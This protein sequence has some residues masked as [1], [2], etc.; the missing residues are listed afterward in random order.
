MSTGSSGFFQSFFNTPHKKKFSKNK[1]KIYENENFHENEKNYDQKNYE[2][3]IEKNNLKKNEKIETVKSDD[4]SG[5]SRPVSF[6]SRN[7]SKNHHIEGNRQPVY[8]EY[9]VPCI[10]RLCLRVNVKSSSR[11]RLYFFHFL[12]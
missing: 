11:Y 5:S 1:N 12:F 9:R 7:S 3:N 2:K 6:E 10:P 4:E 8:E